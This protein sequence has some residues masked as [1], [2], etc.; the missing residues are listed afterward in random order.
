M[1]ENITAEMNK[2]I[3][4][5]R[6]MACDIKEWNEIFRDSSHQVSAK[7]RSSNNRTSS[8]KAEEWE[9]LKSIRVETSLL[10]EVI[11]VLETKFRS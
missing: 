1:K 10:K 9:R 2:G 7:I 3:E 5:F 4:Q 11:K 6:Y 8:G